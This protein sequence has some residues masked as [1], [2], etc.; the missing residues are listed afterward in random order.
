MINPQIKIADKTAEA[1]D[2][3]LFERF[4]AICIEMNKVTGMQL[5]AF[6]SS[7]DVPTYDGKDNLIVWKLNSTEQGSASSKYV[8]QGWRWVSGA[9]LEIRTLTGN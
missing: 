1:F 5:S 8:I 2:S 9:W 6:A 3:D 4:R 7:E